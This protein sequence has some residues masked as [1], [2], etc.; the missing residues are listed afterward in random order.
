MAVTISMK[1]GRYGTVHLL[2]LKD[3]KN[4][5]VKYPYVKELPMFLY[6]TY[7]HLTSCQT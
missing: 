3:D 5:K 6:Y 4:I 7:P 2:Y 1:F